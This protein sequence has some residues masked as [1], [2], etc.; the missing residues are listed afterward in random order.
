MSWRW[1]GVFFL[2]RSWEV[3]Y[4][5]LT[6]WA[7]SGAQKLHAALALCCFGYQRLVVCCF[8]E[9]VEAAIHFILHDP[10]SSS[11]FSF[12]FSTMDDELM[13]TIR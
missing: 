6:L 10:S 12:A 4:F 7:Q 1:A 13:C 11:S 9:K 8:L 3:A 2:A 5:F